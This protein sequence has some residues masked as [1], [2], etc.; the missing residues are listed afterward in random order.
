M[1]VALGAAFRRLAA[2]AALLAAFPLAAQE[3]QGDFDTAERP[4]RCSAE[5]LSPRLD[6]EYRFFTGYT[7]NIPAREMAGPRRA[8]RIDIEIAPLD[9]PEA[10][11]RRIRRTE[12]AGPVPETAR[13]Q[14]VSIT[15]SFVVGEGRYRVRWRLFDSQGGSCGLTWEIEAKRSRSE[16]NVKLAIDPGEV[17]ESR[18]YIFR[19]EST[20]AGPE[21]PGALRLKVFL[22]LDPWRGRGRRQPTSIRMYEFVPRLA[23]L[24]SLARH[25]SVGSVALVVYSVE[26]QQVYHRNPLQ[27]RIEFRE[28]EKAIEKIQ[29]AF[30]SIEQLGRDR[31]RSFFA[32]LLA[33]EIASGEEID[34]YV[35]L[36]PDAEIGRKLD[37]EHLGDIEP[38]DAPFF[39]LRTQRMPWK[40]LIGHFVAGRGG[41]DERFSTP[42][43]LARAVVR[44]VERIEQ[45]PGG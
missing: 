44:I 7:V 37:R 18:V 9:L 12:F 28:I 16:R 3:R 22:N 39:L 2:A 25:P 29:P 30:V 6:F 8:L 24:R 34:A 13:G 15:G 33:A 14:L 21:A 5:Y 4:L 43:D 27:R 17:G 38:V 1:R 20:R 32:G 11:P 23:A 45:R 26:E 36:G 31:S 40:G 41:K 19:P 10:E 35:F 42:T